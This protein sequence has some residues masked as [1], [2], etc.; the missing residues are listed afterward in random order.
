MWRGTHMSSHLSPPLSFRFLLSPMLGF[1]LLTQ[2]HRHQTLT[3]SLH[4][5][6]AGPHRPPLLLLP[7]GEAGR[8]DGSRAWARPLA[9]LTRVADDSS[10]GGASL[11]ARN[12]ADL[13]CLPHATVSGDGSSPEILT[14][15]EPLP[16]PQGGEGVRATASLGCP[17]S[18]APQ[19]PATLLPP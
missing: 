11:H 18:C 4:L 14:A 19:Y 2:S 12:A 9:L 5:L 8:D 17:S 13:H 10:R 6:A 3:S 15:G 16:P 7:V 1:L